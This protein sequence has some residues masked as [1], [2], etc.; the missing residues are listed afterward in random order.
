[1]R[2]SF[3]QSTAKCVGP[4]SGFRGT[5]APLQNIPATEVVEFEVE[6]PKRTPSKFKRYMEDI[7]KLRTLV[8]ESTDKRLDEIQTAVYPGSGYDS[9]YPVS[10]LKNLRLTI[11]FD[12]NAFF[13]P[14]IF[15]SR[16]RRLRS[17]E[18][19]G[20][21]RYVYGGDVQD[22]PI[23]TRIVANLKGSDP[24][25][26]IKSVQAFRDGKNESEIN[27]LVIYDHGDGTP[28]CAYLHVNRFLKEDR[29]EITE[30]E[31]LNLWWM[32][33][34]PD[35]R[36]ALLYKGSAIG[37]EFVADVLEKK[38]AQSEGGIF[39]APTVEVSKR[40]RRNGRFIPSLEAPEGREI[41][42]PYFIRSVVEMFNF[43]FVL[44]WGHEVTVVTFP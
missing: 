7:A 37:E 33:L 26:K 14:N 3:A 41:K 12:K 42:M 43:R 36:V 13:P 11:A 31:I 34:I 29:N 19:H 23:A 38:L 2:P 39:V 17:M 4:F 1:M 20:R 28:L 30:Q 22:A 5:L 21:I 32:K 15:S 25:I 35:N 10:L 18:P 6:A 9:A 8:N 24:R 27:G 44:G 40:V 16:S